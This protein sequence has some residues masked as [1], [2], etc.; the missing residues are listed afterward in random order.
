MI[1]AHILPCSLL[2]LT[3]SITVSKV[4]RPTTIIINNNTTPVL[5]QRS[6]CYPAW[7]PS[8]GF[9][10]VHHAIA[11][12][13]TRAPT[14]LAATGRVD[15][16]A[17]ARGQRATAQAAIRNRHGG[18]R[19]QVRTAAANGGLSRGLMAMSE[20]SP[21]SAVAPPV[22]SVRYF[23]RI[24]WNYMHTYRMLSLLASDGGAALGLTREQTQRGEEPTRLF[25][26]KRTGA[27]A[28][29]PANHSLGSEGLFLPRR[30]DVCCMYVLV[31][32]SGA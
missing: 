11:A 23:H 4:S 13:S 28:R 32:F 1:N 31:S 26:P 18:R 12:T 16:R 19:G 15:G 25:D 14:F 17:G 27:N 29:T 9:G 24:L 6:V 8:A 2:P 7:R 5:R 3:M 10:F 20:G 21:S 30:R 22:D